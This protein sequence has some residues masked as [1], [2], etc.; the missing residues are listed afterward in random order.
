MFIVAGNWK[1]NLNSESSYEL[2]NSIKSIETKDKVIL[3]PPF[4]YLSLVAHLTATTNISLGGQNCSEEEK[5]AFTGDVSSE[6]LKDVGC[7]YVIIGHSERRHNH[8]ETNELINKKLKRA[9]DSGLKVIFC[10]GETL[11]QRESGNILNVLEKQ[12]EEGLTIDSNVDNTIIAYEPIWAI[13]TGRTAKIEEV[14]EVFD[15]LKKTYKNKIL[16]GGSVNEETCKDLKKIN[17]LDGFL[18]GG[19]SIKVDSF[20]KIIKNI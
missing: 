8:N 1:M 12:L 6:M 19:A 9:H 11:E 17:N 7:E 18:I 3:F 16:Y 2:T 13:G 5:G 4:T 14:E 15:S 10:I 20:L